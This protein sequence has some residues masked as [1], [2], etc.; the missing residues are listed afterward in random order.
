MNKLRG[1]KVEAGPPNRDPEK[2]SGSIDLLGGNVHQNIDIRHFLPKGGKMVDSESVEAL[3]IYTG[4]HT[5]LQ[6]NQ[7]EHSWKWSQVDIIINY[8]T[9]INLILVILMTATCWAGNIYYNSTYENHHYT[10]LD[11]EE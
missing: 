3:V 11:D 6:M 10:Y 1:L 4:E 2:F 5:K 9:L 7:F 8:I